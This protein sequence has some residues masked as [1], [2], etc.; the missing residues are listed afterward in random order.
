MIDDHRICSTLLYWHVR[1]QFCTFKD[2]LLTCTY[3]A[4]Q[5]RFAA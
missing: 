3:Y 5:V 4:S 1:A 2:D